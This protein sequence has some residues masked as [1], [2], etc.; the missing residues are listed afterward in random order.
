MALDTWL[1]YLVATMALS[2]TPG[3]NTLLALTHGA[4]YG[5]R[6]TLFTIAGGAVGFTLVVAFS[7]IGIGA[8]L[9]TSAHFLTIMKWVGGAYLIW[10]GIQVW[11]SPPPVLDLEANAPT[12]R[13]GK[14][15]QQ[16]LISAVANPKAILFFSAFLPQ[17][18]DPQRSLFIQFVIMAAT[19]VI[20]EI[21]TETLIANLS[22]RVR[23]WLQHSGRRFNQTCGATFVAI[24]GWLPLSR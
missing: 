9:Q 1:I 17:F 7:M 15:F 18:I 3:P 10:L 19:F 2:L 20:L 23:G 13:G 16:G 22:Y 8:L 6:K 12:K 11:R 4:L 24:G 14:L 5:Q 21:I